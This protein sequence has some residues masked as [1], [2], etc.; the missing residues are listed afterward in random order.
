MVITGGCPR[1]LKLNDFWMCL[2]NCF[3]LKS[4]LPKAL[5]EVKIYLDQSMILKKNFQSYSYY[6]YIFLIG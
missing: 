5:K 1:P 2:L 4:Y 3:L 6:L